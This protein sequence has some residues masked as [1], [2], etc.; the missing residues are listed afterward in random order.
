MNPLDKARLWL[1]TGERCDASE[2]IFAVCSG[3]PENEATGKGCPRTLEDL[4]RCR[5]LLEQCPEMENKLHRVGHLSKAWAEI[6]SFW[7][8]LCMLQDL[9]DPDWRVKAG[10]AP[11]TKLMLNT[12][13][14]RT[15]S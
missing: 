9:E 2:T 4:R 6:I 5:L 7:G 14:E 12:I 3:S 1:V 13:I 10:K 11:K 8:D 15:N